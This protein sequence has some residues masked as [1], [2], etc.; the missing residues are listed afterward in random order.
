[1]DDFCISLVWVALR[2]K[3]TLAPALLPGEC[4]LQLL[5]ESVVQDGPSDETFRLHSGEF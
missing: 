1:M 3:V 5:Q 4:A 2:G